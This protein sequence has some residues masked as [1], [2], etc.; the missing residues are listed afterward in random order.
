MHREDQFI[1]E[2]IVRNAPAALDF[3]KSVFG[4]EEVH[5]MI[6]PGSGKIMHGELTLDGHKFFV[7][8][9]FPASEGGTCKSPE[10]LGGT[11]VRITLLVDDARRV[12]EHAVAAGARVS[13][14]VQD[15]FWGGRYGKVVDPFGHEWGINQQ[16]KEQSHAETQVAADEFFATRK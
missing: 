10:T 13:M 14:P 5:R 3:Y 12:V 4:A 7:C 8:D 9:E 15:M 11:G 1:P 16:I 2:L 6:K